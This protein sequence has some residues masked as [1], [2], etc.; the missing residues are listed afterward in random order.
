MS[1]YSKVYFSAQRVVQLDVYTPELSSSLA[2]M[3]AF[4]KPR[5]DYATSR[6]RAILLHMI[7]DATRWDKNREMLDMIDVECVCLFNIILSSAHYPKSLPV[8]MVGDLTIMGVVLKFHP[9]FQAFLKSSM[10][11]SKGS[12]EI[13]AR[14]ADEVL[15]PIDKDDPTAVVADYK[16]D[17]WNAKVEYDHIKQF[18]EGFQYH[19]EKVVLMK[20]LAMANIHSSSI[21]LR[22]GHPHGL[23]SHLRPLVPAFRGRP[24]VFPPHVRRTG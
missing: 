4:A 15:A 16:F 20:S 7:E 11:L 8:T 13:T 9:L 12:L 5:L 24:I 17:W 10:A 21:L 22:N 1:D 2:A 6:M 3:E 18:E 14:L 19:A 23:T